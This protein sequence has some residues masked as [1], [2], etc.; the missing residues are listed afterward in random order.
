M[1]DYCIGDIHGCSKTLQALLNKLNI[2][3][4]DHIYFLGDYID[5]GP[6]SKEVI[7]ILMNFDN[8]TLHLGNH[9]EMM[10]N[11]IYEDNGHDNQIWMMNGGW[12]T[13]ESYGGE[14][15]LKHLQFIRENCK[16]ITELDNYYICHAGVY[17]TDPM[18]SDIDFYLWD[19]GCPPPTDGKKLIVGHTPMHID[20]IYESLKTN[21]IVLDN[22]C[23]LKDYSGYGNLLALRLGDMKIIKQKNID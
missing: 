8:I 12:Q 22:G 1:A 20:G 5:R 7:K 2:S 18:N 6:R 17:S 11:S 23:V 15:D 19:R 9:E 13:L 14:V 16:L 10:L 3:E 21:K 4:S